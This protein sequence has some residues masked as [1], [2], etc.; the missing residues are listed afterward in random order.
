MPCC[1][2]DSAMGHGLACQH[3]IGKGNKL[4][5]HLTFTKASHQS[6]PWKCAVKAATLRCVAEDPVMGHGMAWEH[7]NWNRKQTEAA[8]DLQ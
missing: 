1:V 5:L 8:F 2:E 6:K 4:K 3:T 7:Y